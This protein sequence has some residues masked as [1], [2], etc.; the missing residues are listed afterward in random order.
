MGYKMKGFGGFGVSP[1]KQ[2]SAK[3]ALDETK[4]FDP[5][6]EENKLSGDLAS[7][8]NKHTTIPTSSGESQKEMR[9]NKTRV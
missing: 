1:V 6:K 4:Q 9:D 2:Q 3:E 7:T 8:Q 5:D